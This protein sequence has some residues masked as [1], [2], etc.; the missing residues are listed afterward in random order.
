MQHSYKRHGILK[1]MAFRISNL[2]SF[3]K[4]Y[5]KSQKVKDLSKRCDLEMLTSHIAN[6]IGGK[7]EFYPKYG[8]VLTLLPVGK[9]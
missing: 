6:I 3:W 5:F 9:K 8:L 7:G 2:R 4:F 1:K